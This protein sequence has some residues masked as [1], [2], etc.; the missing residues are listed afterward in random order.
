MFLINCCHDCTTLALYLLIQFLLN[1]ILDNF[2]KSVSSLHKSSSGFTLYVAVSLFEVRKM[3]RSNWLAK[4]YQASFIP[5]AVAI[6]SRILN[7]ERG[8][9]CVQL[10][11]LSRPFSLNVSFLRL[12]FFSQDINLCP[13]LTCAF[14]LII[15]TPKLNALEV[16]WCPSRCGQVSSHRNIWHWIYL[17]DGNCSLFSSV[18]VAGKMGQSFLR[19]TTDEGCN[20]FPGSSRLNCRAGHIMVK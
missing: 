16:S 19:N 14:F 7:G 15:H 10:Q 2:K 17:P 4:R 3:R 12:F 18:W 8:A 13:I 9:L 20:E 1:A 6:S 5:V 11:E